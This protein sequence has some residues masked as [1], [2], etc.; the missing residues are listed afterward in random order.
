[1]KINTDPKKIK[2]IL[3]KRI[4]RI[5]EKSSL[6][7]RLSSKKQLRIKL[8]I[9]PTTSDLHL[10]NAVV[11]WKLKEF[12]DLGH[13][14]VFI[15]GDFTA[16]IGDP[17]GRSS[18]RK[19][20]TK[21]EI[22]RNM[23]NY[24]KQIGKILDLEKIELV[25]NSHYLEK[26]KLPEIHKIFHFFSVNK[27]LE[28][29]MFQERKKKNEPIWLH[30]FLYPVFQAYDSVVIKADIE[31]GGSDQL[32]NMM[33]GRHLQSRLGQPPQDILT[34]KL[35]LG[36]DGKKKMSKS[37]GNYIGIQDSPK[38]QYGKIMSIKDDLIPEYFELCTR[39][40][41]KEIE[42]IVLELKKGK[43]NP[44][45]IKALLAREVVSIYH[46]K[47]AAQKAEKEFEAI[48]KD[49]KEPADILEMKIKEG[50]ENILDLLVKT[51]LVSSKTEAKRLILQKGVKINGQIE[52]DWKKNIEVKKNQTIQVGKRKFIKIK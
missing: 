32:F 38:E 35:L 45:T 48:F 30:E 33:T 25:Y 1:M 51:K 18:V 7:K 17:S 8:G 22:K 4:E 9:D 15:I 3:T 39:F 26:T 44:K 27:I 34:T 23:R 37:F 5:V 19:A 46:G 40:H 52:K 49:K 36:T 10:G 20:L 16:Q 14:I 47:K 29:D 6:E 41:L 12:Q 2:E 21:E 13:K 50:K 24:K 43:T 31:V 42:K 11:L 28:R